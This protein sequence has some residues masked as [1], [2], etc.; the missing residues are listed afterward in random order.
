M[1]IRTSRLMFHRDEPES[2]PPPQPPSTF[3]PAIHVP[4]RVSPSR[5][6]AFA[7][8]LVE[9]GTTAPFAAFALALVVMGV[10]AVHN[11]TPPPSAPPQRIAVDIA[12][13]AVTV[14]DVTVDRSDVPLATLIAEPLRSV[15]KEPAAAV[16]A[17]PRHV[18][19][20]ARIFAAQTVIY[21]PPAAQSDPVPAAASVSPR[22]ASQYRVASIIAKDLV[23]IAMQKNGAVEVVP[24]HLGDSLPSGAKITAIDPNDHRVV[25]SDGALGSM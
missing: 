2:L 1:T 16:A 11:L 23:L 22:P 21:T 5:V 15:A 24:Y 12:A 9:S 19:T 18:A 4:P 17:A 6:R 3:I 10:F 13:P 8:W 7:G 20:Q 14:P 25:T